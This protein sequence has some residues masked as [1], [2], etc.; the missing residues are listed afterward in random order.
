MAQTGT[1]S[2]VGGA[3]VNEEPDGLARPS[4]MPLTARSWACLILPAAAFLG[5][6]GSIVTIPPTDWDTLIWMAAAERNSPVHYMTHG[7]EIEVYPCYRPAT[8]ASFWLANK[9]YGRNGWG[10]W[11]NALVYQLLTLILLFFLV[12]RLTRSD[13]AAGIA[14]FFFALNSQ[15]SGVFCYLC[16]SHQGVLP[17]L[18]FLVCVLCFLNY[19]DSGKMLLLIAAAVSAWVSVAAK[20]H[21]IASVAAMG[22]LCLWRRK[23]RSPLPGLVACGMVI[24]SY[25]FL[26]YMA[27]GTFTGMH[28][29]EDM[30]YFEQDLIGAIP[31]NMPSGQRT[32][33][34]LYTFG[35][36]VVGT[37]LPHLFGGHGELRTKLLL[38]FPH[39]GMAKWLF[40]WV[41]L[42][43]ELVM[44]TF[45]LLAVSKRTRALLLGSAALIVVV[46]ATAFVEFRFRLHFV[47]VIAFAVMV[48]LAAK[49]YLNSGSR[50]QLLVG[51]VV[52]CLL[53][54]GYVREDTWHI[55]SWRQIHQSMDVTK[56]RFV[57]PNIPA[58]L[59]QDIH[60]RYPPKVVAPKSSKN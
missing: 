19:Q 46:A 4:A 28:P 18:F 13:V 24:C 23:V 14:A 21:G 33:L 59:T 7:V 22:L 39:E 35:A 3:V 6:Y 20:E 32:A 27:L 57:T 54:L 60:K 45:V 16:E 49:A 42:V 29:G 38:A 30:G 31:S 51:G 5:L 15:N 12:R 34:Y 8:H 26:R 25:F 50:W 10:Y 37:F 53:L 1:L 47:G 58:E 17:G 9:T 43:C 56:G 52:L 11:V 36:N 44:L 41:M 55:Q 2:A 48:G 40:S